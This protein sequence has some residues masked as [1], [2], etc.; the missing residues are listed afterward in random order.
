MT[1][2]PPPKP[3][4]RATPLSARLRWLDDDAGEGW[5]LSGVFFCAV[6]GGGVRPMIELQQ[7]LPYAGLEKSHRGGE[8]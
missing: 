6:D 2:L 3:G 4:W 5:A 8:F 1:F 7:P